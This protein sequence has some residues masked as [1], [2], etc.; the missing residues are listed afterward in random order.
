MR[1]HLPPN[2]SASR[3]IS[4]AYLLASAR[5]S[6]E[7]HALVPHSVVNS[8][9]L[10]GCPNVRSV[11]ATLCCRSAQVRRSASYAQMGSSSG[12]SSGRRLLTGSGTALCRACG[13]LMGTTYTS[14]QRWPLLAAVGSLHSTDD[15]V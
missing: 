7:S 15:H 6:S 11:T 9:A 1:Q 5:E 8:G 2:A 12:S 10:L 14:I 13:S 4:A 3:P